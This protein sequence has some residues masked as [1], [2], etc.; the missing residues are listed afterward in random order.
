MEHM[1]KES[2]QIKHK[3]KVEIYSQMFGNFWATK[4]STE[5]A[6]ITFKTL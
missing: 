5:L 1:E 6:L 2:K 3:V 4:R